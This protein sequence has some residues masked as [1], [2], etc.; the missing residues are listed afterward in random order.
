MD[1]KY[2]FIGKPTPR[3]D[4]VDIVTG[5]AK[6]VSDI[7]PPNLLYGKVLRSPH[8]HALIK[9]INTEKA[10]GLQGVRAVLTYKDVPA[11]LKGGKPR[12]LSILDSK[13][14]YVGDAV[15]LV[16]AETE[17]IAE[18]ALGL[19]DVEYEILP[20]VFDVEEAMKPEAPQLYKEFGGNLI[21]PDIP[22]FVGKPLHNV[23]MG[24]VNK[25]FKEADVIVE[26][27]GCFENIPNPLPSEA[28]GA[29]AFWEGP[30]KLTVW[31]S[32]QSPA[33]D[34]IV[35]YFT[36]GR[37]VDVRAIGG[38]CGGSYGSK[39]IM[40]WQVLLHTIFLAKAAGR[41]VKMSY[42]KEEHLAAAALRLASRVH[43]KVGIKKDGTV[44]ALAGDWIINTGFYSAATQGQIA[45][46]SGEIQ[47]ILRCP[48]WDLKSTLVCTNRSASGVVRGFGGLE[49][50]C[51]FAP[52]LN[53]AMEK[54]GIDPVEFFKKNYVKPG[55]GFYWRDSVWYTCRNVDYTKAMARGAEAFGWKEKWKGWLKPTKVDGAKRTGVGCGVHGN[56]DVGEDVSE[57]Y[58]RLDPDGTAMIY[59]SLCE[60]GTGQLSSLTKMVAEVL[61][62]PLE[63]V[64]MTPPDPSLSPYEFGP[65]GS[66]GTYAIGTAFIAAAEDARAKLLQLAG[67]TLKANPEELE[68]VDGMIYTKDNPGKK[69]PWR[70]ALGFDRTC[71]GYGRFEPDY[72][73]P[74][75]MMVFVEVEVDTE[76]GK[77]D[78]VRVVSATDV[79]QII[80]PLTLDN[81]LHGALGTAGLDS[82]TFEET[83]LDRNTGRIMSANMIDY[84]WRTFAELPIFDKVTLE[85]PFPTH[86]F[87]AI[88]VGEITPAPAPWAVLMA[89]SNALGTRLRDYP[90]TPDKV[91]KAWA[92]RQE[93]KNGGH[94]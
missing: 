43:G 80:D 92:G 77:I 67:K 87:H 58:V 71:L 83:V 19:I 93:R 44:T 15:A 28:P 4:A 46:G 30:N 66:R 55:D 94:A 45:V 23:I 78:I 32:T 34:R 76:T 16:A 20:A 68:T 7:F 10:R 63:S 60:M 26:E 69:V 61:Q 22:V 56:A 84:K 52:L 33:M 11:D 13:V 39:S 48:N 36:F 3:R 53:L 91:L 79:G 90:I 2:R 18:E 74:N 50:K 35:L 54:A 5:R 70:A 88:G 81:Q 86:R 38:P 51:A 27:T 29:I 72:T 17:E 47:L 6:F 73:M 1:S 85:T 82:A 49:L 37:K 14:R 89:V 9:N 42:T 41:P 62:I 59:S 31:C 21:P 64:S 57:A 12:H 24:D 75:F 40:Y 8:A 65:A 25:G